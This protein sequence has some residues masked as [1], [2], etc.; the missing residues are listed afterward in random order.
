MSA[1]PEPSFSSRDPNRSL[2]AGILFLSIAAV[3]VVAILSIA[4]IRKSYRTGEISKQPT[5]VA[6]APVVPHPKPSPM[7]PQIR[8][9]SVKYSQGQ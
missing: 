3:L 1:P 6:T 2:S 5:S 7:H 9:T 4:A 8:Q